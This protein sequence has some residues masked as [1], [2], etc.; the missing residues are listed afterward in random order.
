[1]KCNIRITSVII[2]GTLILCSVLLTVHSAP[3][4]ESE[5]PQEEVSITQDSPQILSSDASQHRRSKREII[6]RPLFVY[7]QQQIHKHV[8]DSL[9][10]PK[11]NP[12]KQDID[13]YAGQF[14]AAFFI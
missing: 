12:Y 4:P 6:F 2:I 11:S 1:M 10:L 13:N 7:R 5:R 8:Q 14:P 9:K 3:T